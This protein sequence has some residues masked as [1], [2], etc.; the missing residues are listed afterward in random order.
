MAYTKYTIVA[1]G[2]ESNSF[3]IA[4]TLPYLRKAEVQV[5]VNEEVDGGQA[6]SY[7]SLTWTT[8]SLVLIGGA[9]IVDEDS[10]VFTNTPDITTPQHDFTKNAGVTADKLDANQSQ[11][12]MVSGMILDG[13]F[14][15]A[16][17]GLINMGAHKITNLKDPTAAQDATTKFYVDAFNDAIVASEAAAAASAAAALVSEI[18]VAA[19]E[20]L[21]DA[22]ATATAA[23]VVLTG[24][25]LVATNADVVLTGVDL[26]LTNADVVLTGLD[27]VATIADVVLTHADV[28]LTALDEAATDADATATAADKVATNAD[29][30]LTNADVVL[31]GLDATATAAD[32]VLTGVDVGL[33]G[34]DVTAAGVA[35]TGAEAAE[36]NAAASAVAAAN[37]AKTVFMIAVSDEVTIIETG[38]A[39]ITFRMPY[40]L[41]LTD[42]R[43]SLNVVSSSGIPT[44]DVNEA[45]S[46]ILSTLLTIDASEK[47]SVTAVAAVVISD[48]A[49]ADDAEITIDITIAGTGA[50]GLKVYLIGDPV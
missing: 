34:G 10:V 45:G 19:D 28:V 24:I 14:A 6:P 32:V 11:A 15:A 39:K 20:V 29:V 40:A 42:I 12:L 37:S 50:K 5:R 23:D 13:R 22:D 36:T 1:D 26:G 25:D 3:P 44:I 41:T 35:R 33:T 30:V 27:L 16:F 21:T 18:L 4:F 7:R 2:T 48:T 8:D 49:L 43:A 38:T 46:S 47:S 9:D 17:E 31:T